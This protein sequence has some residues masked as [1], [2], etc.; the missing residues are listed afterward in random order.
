M[1]KILLLTQATSLII[2]LLLAQKLVQEMLNNKKHFS[3]GLIKKLSDE[4]VSDDTIIR[5]VADFVIAAGDTV[6]YQFYNLILISQAGKYYFY[7]KYV[8]VFIF[9]LHT[10]LHGHFIY[11]RKIQKLLTNYGQRVTTMPN[12]LLRRQCVCIQLLHF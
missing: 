9:R 8:A 10:L 2:V 6:I 11:Y 5:L 3:N 1:C 4:N 12:I 7:L